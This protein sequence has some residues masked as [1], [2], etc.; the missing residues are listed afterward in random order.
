MQD[1]AKFAALIRSFSLRTSRRDVL[2]R[3]NTIVDYDNLATFP[4][5]QLDLL[6]LSSRLRSQ[7]VYIS[8]DWPHGWNSLALPHIDGRRLRSVYIDM[9]NVAADNIV[10]MLTRSSATLSSVVLRG[11]R[12]DPH[13]HQRR[14]HF[15]DFPS[16]TD[17]RIPDLC[18][19][20]R[21]NVLHHI[22]QASRNLRILELHRCC[23]DGRNGSS[24]S[25]MCVGRLDLKSPHSGFDM[26]TILH[27]CGQVLE[28]LTIPSL[29]LD[30]AADNSTALLFAANNLRHLT[31]DIYRLS[32][33]PGLPSLLTRLTIAKLTCDF[34]DFL[35]SI[36]S[37]AFTRQLPKL[38]ILSIANLNVEQLSDLRAIAE[39]L[40]IEVSSPTISAKFRRR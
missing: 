33:L 3:R 39:T 4:D 6:W 14:Q 26:S 40:S 18:S 30:P 12:S 32:Y 7:H 8:T 35:H 20:G 19:S 27:S 29:D 34:S 11:H 17:V 38:R 13:F 16:L 9:T 22:L 24:K 21:D 2:D 15:A 1:G 23:V 37:A 5:V 28:S 10:Q 31:L 36:R 25:A